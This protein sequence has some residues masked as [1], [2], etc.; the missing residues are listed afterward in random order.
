MKFKHLPIILLITYLFFLPIEANAALVA[1]QMRYSDSLEKTRI[2]IDLNEE[3]KFEKTEGFTNRIEIL[4]GK[5][6]LDKNLKDIVFIDKPVRQVKLFTVEKDQLLLDIMLNEE[7]NYTAFVLKDPWRLV[8]DIVKEYDIRESREIAPGLTYTQIRQSVKGRKLKSYCL[9]IDKNKWEVKPILAKGEILSR[10]KLKNIVAFHNAFAG[11]NASYFGSDGWVIGNLKIDNEM[12]GL[13]SMTRTAFLVYPDQTMEFE[14]LSYS[15]EVTL[16]NG[17]SLPIKGI[18]RT[19]QVND[20]VVY[21][22]KFAKTTRTNEHGYDVVIDA[23]GNVLAV[24]PQGNSAVQPGQIVISG[25]GIMADYLSCLQ[26]KDKL[27]FG[28]TM[29]EKADKAQHVLGAGPR[30]LQNKRV[31]VANSQ[32][33]FLPD[34][35]NGRAP[36]TAVGLDANGNTIL[37]VADGRSKESSGLTLTELAYEL[38]SFGAVDAMNLDGGGS[39]EMVVGDTI[40]NVPSDK[41]ERRI[42]VA[43][44][45]FAR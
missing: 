9:T 28:Q 41:Q 11:V 43:L 36:R 5:G 12:V 38:M 44:G 21:S 32:E 14:L 27:I 6:T 40:M 3:F 8:I 42:S 18:N 37:Y 24:N 22:S 4:L 1:T 16:P 17:V 29:G 23:K 7:L 26:P 15:G 33:N 34:I 13:E 10:D 31:V 39:S 19:R 35:M 20:L 45:V 25:H 30:L 2:V